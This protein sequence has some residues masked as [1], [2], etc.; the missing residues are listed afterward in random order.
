MD[1]QARW[2]REKLDKA[3]VEHVGE[4]IKIT[5]DSSLL[6]D[7]DSYTL[8]D[9]TKEELDELAAYCRNMRIPKS[10]LLVT[11]TVLVLQNITSCRKSVPSQ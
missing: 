3:E 7:V 11:P 5:F 6:F 10:S 2:L 1:R 9:A 8:R 4:G